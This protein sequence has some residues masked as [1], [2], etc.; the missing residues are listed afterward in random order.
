MTRNYPFLHSTNVAVN[1]AKYMMFY[2]R[3]G[4][5]SLSFK[6]AE[7]R[8]SQWVQTFTGL[9]VAE[10]I[11]DD[12]NDILETNVIEG[13]RHPFMLAMTDYTRYYPQ[14]ITEYTFGVMSPVSLSNK[15]SQMESQ[16]KNGVSSNDVVVDTQTTTT[17]RTGG[18][19]PSDDTTNES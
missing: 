5:R 9:E 12:M 1:L 19:E 11:S 6:M 13:S 8:D 4:G 16:I 10:S 3:W 2:N 14:G 7:F 18:S 17:L 15:V